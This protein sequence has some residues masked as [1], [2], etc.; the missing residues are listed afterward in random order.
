MSHKQNALS[1]DQEMLKIVGMYNV[2]TVCKNSLLMHAVLCLR[3]V[4]SR[5][6]I[7]NAVTL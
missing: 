2:L 4:S 7:R 1:F 3:R 5:G 6:R